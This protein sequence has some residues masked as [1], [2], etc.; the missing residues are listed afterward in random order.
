M[1]ATKNNGNLPK[2][3]VSKFGY[4]YIRELASKAQKERQKVV[5][6]Q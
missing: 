5:S 3:L 1:V 2:A 4:A 6:R